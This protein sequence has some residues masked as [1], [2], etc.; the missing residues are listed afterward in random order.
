VPHSLVSI[1]PVSL[2][3]HP[4]AHDGYLELYRNLS[5]AVFQCEATKASEQLVG[6]LEKFCGTLTADAEHRLNA[7][8]TSGRVLE[9]AHTQPAL[10]AE[11]GAFL[12]AID[13]AEAR[14]HELVMYRQLT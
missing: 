8:Y 12:S 7:A 1:I 5:C 11:G 13:V 4:A 9:T 14:A 3:G 10:A 2:I 6:R